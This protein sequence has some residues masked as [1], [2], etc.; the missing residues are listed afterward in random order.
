MRIALAAMAASAVLAACMSDSPSGPQDPSGR[1]SGACV[2]GGCSSELCADQ[3]LVSPCI[4]R[5]VNACYDNA[6][7]GRQPDGSCGWNPTPEL[8]ACIASH[9]D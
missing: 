5:A 6:L 4:W 1:Q 7:C 3:P 2:I 9:A 8:T